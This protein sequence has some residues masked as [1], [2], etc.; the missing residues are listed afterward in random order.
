MRNAILVAVGVTLFATVASV[1]T[2]LGTAADEAAIKKNVDAR[3]AAWNKH[4]SKA[5][6]ALYAS[7]A[8]RVTVN[9]SFA[10]RAQIEKS[11]ADQFNDVYKSATLKEDLGKIRFLTP[12]VAIDDL[13]FVITGATSGIVNGHAAAIYMK[14]NGEWTLVAQRNIRK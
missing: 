2:K 10:G 13:D 5:I 4:D 3:F 1:Q 7:D 9:G 12:E 11:Y 8:D 14:R 6:A